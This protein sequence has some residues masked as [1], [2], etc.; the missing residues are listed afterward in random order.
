MPQPTS[1][2]PPPAH[3][4]GEEWRDID[5]APDHYNPADHDEALSL[6]KR[7]IRTHRM[8]PRTVR[9][10][11][12][13][14]KPRAGLPVEIIQ[15]SSDF[16]VGDNLWSLDAHWR[17]GRWDGSLA[18]AWRSRY[19]DI[20]NA[21]N[22]LSYWTE[23]PRND[24]AKTEEHQG[25]WRLDGFAAMVD[26][27][28]SRGMLAKGHPLFWSIPKC[29]PD[30]VQRYDYDTQMKFAEVRV[31]NIVARFRGRV[32]IYDAV[33]EPMWEA[34]FK[35][36][37]KR[38]WPHMT[39]I[40]D[41]ADYIEPVLR[42]CRAEDPDAT[43]LVN[44]YGMCAT[45]DRT[46]KGSDGSDVTASSQRARY[47]QLFNEL[48][49]RGTPADG[50]GLQGHTGWVPHR[51]QYHVFDQM[52]TGTGLP[53]HITEFWARTHELRAKG[54]MPDHEID[55]L[56]AEYVANTLT[57]AFG[58]PGVE[59]FFFWGLMGDAIDWKDN[60]GNDPKPAYDR[61]RQLLREEWRTAAS[62]TT[63]AQGCVTFDGFF[64]GY[65]A[66]FPVSPGHRTGHTFSHDRRCDG[67]VT[68]TV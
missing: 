5:A 10:V 49:D 3:L 19:E 9:F 67:T 24:G 32:K 25:D 28:T 40:Q 50:V 68:L 54:T 52:H 34:A 36:L 56:H 14:G 57:V 33:N 47:I 60:G 31:R 30:W 53:V 61:V 29:V 41:I 66:R 46:L 43:F 23:R 58:H 48:A 21:A 45:D 39:P 20:F 2:T 13:Q 6:A 11:D 38:D 44:D 17:N 4:G 37:A 1:P 15:Q 63:D 62:A 65:T 42:W 59:A 27:V 22:C 8:G 16:P 12:R 18:R 51:L 64:G 35:D 7:N 26:W 55:L